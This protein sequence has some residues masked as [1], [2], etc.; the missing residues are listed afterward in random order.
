MAKININ[1]DNK[2]FNNRERKSFDAFNRKM[3]KK[4]IKRLK[5]KDKKPLNEREKFLYETSNLFSERIVECENGFYK[6]NGVSHILLT[7]TKTKTERFYDETKELNRKYPAINFLPSTIMDERHRKS[8]LEVTNPNKFGLQ[9]VGEL[10]PKTPEL[11]RY[12]RFVV[13]NAFGISYDSICIDFEVYYSGSFLEDF[14]KCLI[15][16]YPTDVEYIRI[17]NCGRDSISHNYPM[18]ESARAQ[19]VDD[20]L[21]EIKIRMWEFLRHNYSVF[22]FSSDY[23]PLSIDEYRTNLNLQDRFIASYD[24]AIFSEEQLVN[25]SYLDSNNKTRENSLFLN[26]HNSFRRQFYELNRFRVLFFV[27]EDSYVYLHDSLDFVLMFFLQ[28][29]VIKKYKEIL[30]SKYE[31]FE[32]IGNG[33]YCALS[34]VFKKYCNLCLETS[35]YQIFLDFNKLEILPYVSDSKRLRELFENIKVSV[36]LLNER[37]KELDNKIN[38]ILTSKNN[39][40]SIK[41][42]LIALAVSILSVIAAIVAIIIPFI[43]SE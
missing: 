2:H 42:A 16:D 28:N 11:E 36:E 39:S 1:I 29:N 27:D 7:L 24:Y 30:N 31:L 25:F 18:Q 33:K 21:F 43:F 26:F 37:N 14:N 19:Y 35:N 40:S 4:R 5:N 34:N 10:T 12:I 9:R 41:V 17:F 23:V 3:H 32:R 38:N 13:I 6:N 22:D 15:D 20:V 8:F